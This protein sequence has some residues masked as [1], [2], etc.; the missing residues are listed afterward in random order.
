MDNMRFS[1]ITISQEPADFEKTEQWNS[2]LDLTYAVWRVC[3]MTIGNENELLKSRIKEIAAD[4]LT[5]YAGTP[6]PAEHAEKSIEQVNAQIALL[7]LAQ[8][9]SGAKEINFV[10]LKNEYKRFGSLLSRAM[11]FREEEKQHAPV[12]ERRAFSDPSAVSSG[13]NWQPAAE[14]RDEPMREAPAVRHAPAKKT[15]APAPVK[16]LNDRQVKIVQFFTKSKEN[17]IKLKSIAQVF[18]QLTDRTI[19]NDLKDLCDKRIIARSD[20]FGQSSYY[21]LVRK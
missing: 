17:K 2:L 19:R 16:T 7:S 20:G 14:K 6:R 11:A 18:P 1:H 5:G 15:T 8:R 3:D 4:I 9:I 21:Y 12:A 10:I 13:P